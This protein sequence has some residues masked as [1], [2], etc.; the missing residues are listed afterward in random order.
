MGKHITADDVRKRILE[1]MPDPLG[2]DFWNLRNELAWLHIKWN[3]YRMG[4]MH[5]IRKRLII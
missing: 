5:V 3:N 2:S 1:A 4:S